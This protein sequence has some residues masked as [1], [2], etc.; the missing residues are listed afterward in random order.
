MQTSPQKQQLHDRG[1][2]VVIPTYN[3]AG[4]IADVVKRTLAQCNDVIVVND[5]CTDNTKAILDTIDGIVVV[6]NASNKGK[7]TALKRGFKKAL[8][9]GFAYAITLDGDGQHYPE[10][11]PLL[12][13]ANINN[14]GC[15]ILGQ[16]KMEGAERSKGSKFANAFSNFWFCVQTLHYL[17]DTQTGYRLYPL[18]KIHGL[19]LLTSR[20][21]AELELLVFAAWHGVKIIPVEINVYYPPRAER[22]SHFRPALDF[23]RISI[24]NTILCVLAIVYGLPCAI[25]RLL[26]ATLVTVASLLTYLIECFF[27]IT[28]FALLY[29]PFKKWRR[30]NNNQMHP[31]MHFCGKLT[32]RIL[33]LLGIKVTIRNPHKETFEKPAIIVC[34]HQSHLDLIVQLSMTKKIVFLT[35]DWVNHSHFFGYAIRSAE[36]HPISMG[37]DALFPKLK[38]LVNRGY[39]ISIFPEGTRSRDCSIQ[40]FH[41]GAF[42]LAEQ[43]GIDI[44]PL[45]LYGAGKALPKKGLYMR[46]HPI[47]LDI[48]QRIAPTQLLSTGD[49]LQER[50]KWFRH[51]YIK[52]YGELSNEMEQ[53]V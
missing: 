36:Y 24:L 41:K 12:L 51:H 21:E 39:S 48:D 17:P 49:T 44:L 31:L 5:G 33:C 10:D 8:E 22:V 45:V 16:R 29:A 25:L 9:L 14:P 37:I 11:I 35:N 43:L 27:I 6:E 40:R 20:Y 4:T 52:R 13:D 19:S 46:C 23:T 32:T 28:P 7:G 2:C 3:N 18:H 47:T 26:R 34:N 38:D 42:L 50:S 15:I 1:I 30:N 53:H